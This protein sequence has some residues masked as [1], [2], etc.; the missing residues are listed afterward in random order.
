VQAYAY[1]KRLGVLDLELTDSGVQVLSYDYVTIDDSILGDAEV[2]ALLD[3]FIVDL[4]TEVL[5]PRGYEFSAAVAETAFDLKKIYGEEHNLGDLVTDAIIWSAN[6]VLDDPEDPV[7]FAV[8]SDGVI[9]DAILKGATG[10]INT[11]DAFRVVPL[12]LDPLS[13]TAGYPL[14]SFYLTGADVRKACMVDC[15]API[16][17][18]SNYWLSYSG[19]GFSHA[20]VLLVNAWQC[21]DPFDPTCEDRTPIPDDDTLYRVAVNYYV[22]L[23]IERMAEV[24]GGLLEVVPRDKNGD[25]LA[26]LTD[27]IIYEADGDPLAQWEGFL[28]YLSSF[29]DTDADGIPNI[30][31]RYSGPQG[32]IVDAC[33]V[34]TAAYGTPFAEKIDVLREFRDRVLMKSV[35]GR[36]LVDAYYAC[37]QEPAETVAGSPVLRF[38]VRTLLLP[39][40]GLAKVLLLLV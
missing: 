33:F 7:S 2:Q 4:D 32:R 17:N 36:K 26:D 15:F 31:E 27:A 14:L 28:A 20:S 39:V 9:R 10:R 13:W 12:G 16:L 29:P 30:P 23:N 24:S 18:D 3:T 34:A 35:A 8:E 38:L 40:I 1:T 11:S 5:G 21:H 37:A 6:Q 19:L 22:A 25:P